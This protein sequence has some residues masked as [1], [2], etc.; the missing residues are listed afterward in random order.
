MKYTAAHPKVTARA[1]DNRPIE[2][3]MVSV[4]VFS[5]IAAAF[6]LD[7]KRKNASL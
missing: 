4:L 7:S 5:A 3:M 2:R 1:G 6:T